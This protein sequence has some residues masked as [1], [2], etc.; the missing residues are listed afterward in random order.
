M[1]PVHESQRTGHDVRSNQVALTDK[2]LSDRVSVSTEGVS[3]RFPRTASVAPTRCIPRLAAAG[4][5]SIDWIRANAN[6]IGA[7]YIL[8]PAI[9]TSR[10]YSSRLRGFESI[11]HDVAC[12]RKVGA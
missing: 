8:N 7:G 10:R 9:P 1:R 3:G 12:K 6:L 2:R 11:V 4:G 5:N